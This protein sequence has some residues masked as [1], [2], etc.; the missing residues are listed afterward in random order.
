MWQHAAV[1]FDAR[2]LGIPTHLGIARKH[3]PKD[4]AALEFDK[5][6]AAQAVLMEQVPHMR[7][8][9]GEFFARP[10]DCISHVQCDRFSFLLPLQE[11][12]CFL[13]GTSVEE[14][15]RE[16][17]Y[18][19]YL[20]MV[21]MGQADAMLVPFDFSVPLRASVPGRR[22]R[23]MVCSLHRM[24]HEIE[25]MD[26]YT[27]IQETI[28]IR[29]FDAFVSLSN[30]AME[31]FERVQGVGRRFWAKWALAALRGLA[32]RA[33]KNQLPVL[34]DPQHGEMPIVE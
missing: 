19:D 6:Q 16:N 15:M 7:V 3:L 32:T 25:M 22:H 18:T 1:K 26:E 31:R 34:I 11:Y 17:S 9:I 24:V 21:L 5:I 8:Q 4:D 20:H 29:Q 27:A 13:N 10:C 14:V 30:A 28:G 33:L 2:V 12:A 23:Y